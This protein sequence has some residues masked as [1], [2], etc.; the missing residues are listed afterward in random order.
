[1]ITFD[2]NTNVTPQQFDLVAS[3]ERHL[4]E[5]PSAIRQCIKGFSPYG[6]LVP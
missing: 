5:N 1:M 6:Y 3:F 2:E 4:D